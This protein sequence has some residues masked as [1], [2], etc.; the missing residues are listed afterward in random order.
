LV[1]SNN[2]I[3]LSAILSLDDEPDIGAADS[4]F[5][6]AVTVPQHDA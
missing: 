2:T 4:F 5:G 6:A 1:Q 3:V